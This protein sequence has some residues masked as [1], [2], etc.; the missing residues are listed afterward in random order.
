LQIIRAHS[1]SL[2]GVL[3][4]EGDEVLWKRDAPATRFAAELVNAQSEECAFDMLRI[5]LKTQFLVTGPNL[6][7]SDL[8]VKR[9]S[10]QVYDAAFVVCKSRPGARVVLEG[11]QGTGKSRNLIYL[12][13]KLL[14]SGT[15]VLLQSCKRGMMYAFV[16]ADGT[17]T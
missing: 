3:V 11:Q 1:F 14:E 13:K 4:E 15:L 2:E 7:G 9:S 5:P 12:L 6:G 16:P 8:I 10:R 17:Y